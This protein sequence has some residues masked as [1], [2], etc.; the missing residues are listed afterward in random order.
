MQISE[1]GRG[2]L[3]LYEDEV[4]QKLPYIGCLHGS[5]QL[6]LPSCRIRDL[7]I[8]RL[9]RFAEVKELDLDEVF[10]LLVEDA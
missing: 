10:N 2:D 1:M 7:K 8:E 9:P 6:G 5:V 3:F 4:Y